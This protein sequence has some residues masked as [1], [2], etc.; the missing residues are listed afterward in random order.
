MTGSDRIKADLIIIFCC[1]VGFRRSDIGKPNISCGEFFICI[2]I[3]A[4]QREG[5]QHGIKA[6]HPPIDTATDERAGISTQFWAVPYRRLGQG[7]IGKQSQTGRTCR[8]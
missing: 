5:A 1:F 6:H 4:G 3:M 2:P 8:P 7:R